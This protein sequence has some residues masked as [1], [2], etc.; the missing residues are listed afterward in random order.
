MNKFIAALKSAPK[1]GAALAVIAA[2][3][4]VPAGLFA[5]GP[6]RPTYTVEQ[7]ADHVTFNSITNNPYYGDERNFV[8]VKD[9]ATGKF[10]DTVNVQP[11]Q[12]Y[13]VRVLAHNN[14]HESLNLKATNTVLKTVLSPSTA[15][16]NAITGYLSADN[17]QPQ[18]IHDDVFFKSEKDFNL[19]YIP[20]SARIYNNGYA[21]GGQGKA[22]SD[23][24]VTASGAR[25]GYEAEGDGIVPGC[26]Q[27]LSYV[28]FKV[29]PQFA[30]QPDFTVAKT[31]SKAGENKWQEN[32]TVN[33][34]DTVD[35]R[36]EYK[37]TGEV[38][39]DNVVVKD[40]LPAHMS[41]VPGTAKLYNTQ[42][43][44]GFQLSDKVVTAEG[45]NIGS[46]A[47]GATSFVVFKAKVNAAAEL[48]CGTNKLTNKAS[49]ETDHGKKEDTADVTVPKECQ[50]QPK[51]VYTCDA[52][53]VSKLS[54]NKFRFE[55]GYTVK[56]GTY[57]SV[58][59]VVRDANGKE[60]ARQ[61]VTNGTAWDYTQAT[62]GKY[63][64]EAVVTFTVNGQ[65]VT[66]GG[67][68]CKKAFEVVAPAPGKIVVCDL[69]SKQV[70]VINENQFDASKHSKNMEDC[71]TAQPV[72][73][74]AP[75][76]PTAPVSPANLPTTG[77]EDALSTFV[78]LGAIVATLGYFIT[79]RRSLGQ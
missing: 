9:P 47:A 69:T 19:A 40:T 8:T 29:K 52:L 70:V 35:Y 12:E 33:A 3:V 26:F 66:A 46:H 62:A 44:Q 75:V 60:I 64:V 22:F 32:V 54:E 4:L 48:E 78:G 10:V 43:P 28:Y 76:A 74:A 42:H 53:G 6:D 24:L 5:W 41:Y 61:T 1:R 65:E 67:E 63:T 51:P 15:K 59:Y 16:E 31:V 50:E 77:S 23:N 36:I 71:K 37:N 17:A 49:V 7:A 56:N 18:K 27:Y 21:A 25:L 2:A 57:K 55:T 45:V 73:P 58:T 20:G 39:Q 68:H 30:A 79:A 14:A 11:G 38:Q 34:G 72:A 13:E